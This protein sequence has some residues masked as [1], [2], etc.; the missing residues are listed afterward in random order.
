M[1][2]A[3]GDRVVT[4]ARAGANGQVARVTEVLGDDGAPPYRVEY[5]DG[6]TAVVGPGPGSKTRSGKQRVETI[7]PDAAYL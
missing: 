5:P 3:R 6:R 7:H 4:R 2:A 1:Q